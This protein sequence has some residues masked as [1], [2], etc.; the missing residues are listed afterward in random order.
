MASYIQG[1]RLRRAAAALQ[2]PGDL[3]K[4]SQIALAC[5]FFA[6]ST[7]SRMFRLRFG[8]TSCEFHE[9]TFADLP[10][11]EARGVPAGSLAGF[12]HSLKRPA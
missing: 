3:R 8:T 4:V 12:L 2:D 10:R 7:F 11:P 1:E 6:H 9:A 5:G